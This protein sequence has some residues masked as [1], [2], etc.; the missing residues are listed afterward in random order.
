MPAVAEA[1]SGIPPHAHFVQFGVGAERAMPQFHTHPSILCNL[2]TSPVQGSRVR[3]DVNKPV[4][5]HY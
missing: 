4:F 3:Y 5:N 2:C 1:T